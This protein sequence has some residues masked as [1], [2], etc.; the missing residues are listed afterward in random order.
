MNDLD[1]ILNG[2]EAPEEIVEPAPAEPES[3]P[4]PIEPEPEPDPQPEETP[5]PKG[6]EDLGEPPSPKIEDSMV[7]LK[8]LTEERRKRQELEAQLN[9]KQPNKAPDVL[10]D[11]EGYTQ[12]ISSQI[13]QQLLN[14]RL[15]TSEFMARKEFADLDA[16]VQKF[17]E[18]VSEN[19][20]LSQQVFGAVSPYH[21]IVDVVNKAEQ[22][23]QMQDVDSYKAKLRAEVEAEIKAEYEAK[24]KEKTD[25]RESI[26]PSLTNVGSKGGMKG[27]D[28]AGPTTLDSILN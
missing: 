13:S 4:A 7:P 5:E 2:E 11:Q 18:M 27:A 24:A 12:H 21:E 16:K 15:N 19:P 8:A 28:W 22:F 6:E 1:A 25:L 14:E 26:P 9:T 23:E 3:E 17:Q 10:E 20:A